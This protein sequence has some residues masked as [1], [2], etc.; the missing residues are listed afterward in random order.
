MTD[1]LLRRAQHTLAPL[2]RR[3]LETAISL[4]RRDPVAH[5]VPLMH[6]ETARA[7]GIMTGSLW[8]VRR[9]SGLHSSLVGL[10]WNGANLSPVLPEGDCED[11]D[12]LRAEVAAAAIARLTRPAALVGPAG[13]TLDLW[14]RVEPWW[15]P[16]REVRARQVSMAI[17]H[18]PRRV[19]GIDASGLD[20]EAVR[21]ATL[22]DYDLL[23]PACV[24]MFIG[25]VGYDPMRHG[26]AGYEERLRYLVRAGR[27]Y[28]QMGT[29]DGRRQVVFKAEVGALGGGVA[30]LQGV[31]VHPDLRGRGLARAGLGA[32][33]DAARA[34]LAP[35]VSL[36]VNDFNPVA[37]RAY[38]AV[39]FR[40]VGTFATVMM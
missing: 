34:Q 9:R 19:A 3:D 16:A 21:R 31:W 8:G 22:D 15:G 39:G 20:L 32:V 18:D 24:H 14:G 26:R 33:I 4:A 2:Q 28:I 7:S 5:V 38:D 10:V 30:Q 13:V 29:V 12:S 37:I 27:S 1:S 6:L 23:L 11:E 40:E 17:D 25:E 36:Y 35:T